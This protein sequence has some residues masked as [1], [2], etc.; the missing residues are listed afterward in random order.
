MSSELSEKKSRRVFLWLTIVVLRKLLL[1]E[2]QGR[3]RNDFV[4][5]GYLRVGDLDEVDVQ[6][7]C[8]VVDVLELGKNLVAFRALRLSCVMSNH[9]ECKSH[10]HS[11]HGFDVKSARV[12]E[13][14]LQL[15]YG[16]KSF[17]HYENKR[18][19]KRTF[20]IVS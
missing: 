5:L 14:L 12:V 3:Q 8:F 20:D 7:L 6:C 1:E 17:T 18:F 9:C 11:C 2:H 15:W 10:L 4:S 19:H 16:N 13:R